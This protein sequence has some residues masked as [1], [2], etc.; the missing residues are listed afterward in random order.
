MVKDSTIKDE[1]KFAEQRAWDSLG[2][3]KFWMFGY[4]ASRW[5]Y[6]AQ[7][8]KR[9]TNERLPNPFYSLVDI[10][11]KKMAPG[12]A[13]RSLLF[14]DCSPGANVRVVPSEKPSSLPVFPK[15]EIG[16]NKPVAREKE[17]SSPSLWPLRK[18]NR[19]RLEY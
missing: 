14:P 7:L 18:L 11:K 6:L 12:S 16:E 5:V 8:L 3:Y 2:R 4:F 10:A 9:E 15:L 19:K 13:S 1:L 17:H